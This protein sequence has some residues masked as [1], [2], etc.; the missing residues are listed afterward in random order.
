MVWVVQP[1]TIEYHTLDDFKYTHFSYNFFYILTILN[2]NGF[3]WDW[4]EFLSSL[5][6]LFNPTP[7]CPSP[8]SSLSFPKRG[9]VCFLMFYLWSVDSMRHN[10][11]FLSYPSLFFLAHYLNFHLVFF[12]GENVRWG[13]PHVRSKGIYVVQSHD[14]TNFFADSSILPPYRQHQ[15]TEQ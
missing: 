2:I 9:L 7:F 8:H 5:T 12:D 14:G 10:L 13:S 3:H 6:I 4:F 11:S 15:K 1:A